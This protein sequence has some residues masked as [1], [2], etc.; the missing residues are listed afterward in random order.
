[1]DRPRPRRQPLRRMIQAV[2]TRRAAA[3]RTLAFGSRR[4]RRHRKVWHTV[5]TIRAAHC[6]PARRPVAHRL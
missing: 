3:D 6:R 5:R 1:M 4:H 2:G